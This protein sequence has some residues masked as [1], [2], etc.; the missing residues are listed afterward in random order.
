MNRRH[1]HTSTFH[2]LEARLR[3]V[4]PPALKTPIVDQL[5]EGHRSKPM[6]LAIRCLTFAGYLY[7]NHPKEEAE[8]MLVDLIEAV[9]ARADLADKAK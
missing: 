1:R 9:E 7:S 8:R 5:L 2:V 6:D 3:G 4:A